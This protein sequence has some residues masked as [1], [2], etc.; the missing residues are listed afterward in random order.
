MAK[1]T[2][3]LKGAKGKLAGFTLQKGADGGTIMRETVTPKNPQTE[4]QKIQRAVIGTVGKAYSTMKMICDHSFEGY[5]NGAQCMNRFR[6][7]NANRLRAATANLIDEGMDMAAIYD[8]NSAK[9]AL[10]DY[11]VS[12]GSLNPV[13][14]ALI[15]DP[16]GNNLQTIIPIETDDDPGPVVIPTYADV[17]EKLGLKRGDQLTICFI[18]NDQYTEKGF[19]FTY[20]RI[21]LSPVLNGD[22]APMNTPFINGDGLINAANPRNEGVSKLVIGTNGLLTFSLISSIGN[23]Q[24]GCIIASRKVNNTWL[25]SYAV[26]ATNDNSSLDLKKVSLLEAINKSN[27]INI[28]NNTLYLNNATD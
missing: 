12:E 22:L 21:I 10:N 16:R 19:N 24:A 11:V 14:T 18:Y 25:R 2:G 13:R 5:A 23:I 9:L 8:F 7:L 4:L 28:E 6:S 1:I 3:V 27:N 17:C 15:V 20:A 26:M